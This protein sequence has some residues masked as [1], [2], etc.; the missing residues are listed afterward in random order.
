MR[1]KKLPGKERD[2][3]FQVNPWPVEGQRA[4]LGSVCPETLQQGVRD[5]ELQLQE[6]GVK[7]TLHRRGR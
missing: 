5:P 2:W 7:G 4:R 1:E 6:K 3:S